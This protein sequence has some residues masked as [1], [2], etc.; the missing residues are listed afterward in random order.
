MRMQLLAVPS[1]AIALSLALLLPAAAAQR[2]PGARTIT[3]ECVNPALTDGLRNTAIAN[4]QQKLSYT[5]PPWLPS[6]DYN[7]LYQRNWNEMLNLFAFPPLGPAP[8]TA[9]RRP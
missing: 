6:Q 5:S 2:C 4:T 1:S 3:G 7:Y 9:F 8:T